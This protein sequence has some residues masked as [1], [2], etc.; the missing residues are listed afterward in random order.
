MNIVDI[1][2]PIIAISGMGVLFGIGLG[3]A[4]KVF[5]VPVDER[6]DE[7]KNNLPGA[8]C[9]G[10]GFAG[11]EAFAKAVA[12]G[13]A[14]VSGCPVSND[15]QIAA[16]AEIMGVTPIIGEKEVAIIRC[17]GN[18]DVAKTKYNYEGIQ[19]CYDAMLIHGGP[20]ICKYGCIGLGT[21]AKVCSFDAI[22]MVNGMPSI[23]TQKCVACNACVSKCPKALLYIGKATTKYQVICQ[24]HDKG[25]DVKSGCSVGCIGCSICVKQCEVNAIKVE[26]QLA[27]IDDLK[28]VGCGKCAEKCPT[29]AIMKF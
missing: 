2:N 9:G 12:S 22:K 7:I 16:I 29:K 18:C 15:D 3:I 23:D 11:C 5:S 21:C 28:C 14:S 10:C 27:T 17:Q 24:S 20:K 8:N 19:S 4:S 25:K 6:V 1:I 13:D 26:N